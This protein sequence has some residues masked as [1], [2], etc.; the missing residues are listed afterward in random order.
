MEENEYIER[1]FDEH[2]RAAS[3]KSSLGESG[4]YEQI[5]LN[6]KYYRGDQQNGVRLN[7]GNGGALRHNIVRRIGDYKRA[8]IL[9]DNF[10]VRFDAA[11]IA[12][13]DGIRKAALRLKNELC[14]K[15]ITDTVGNDYPIELVENV[16]ALN[17]TSELFKSAAKNCR[18]NM[19]LE[20]ALKNAY[21]SGSGVV[22]TYWDGGVNTG[23]YADEL[24]RTPILGDIKAAVIGIADIDFGDCNE[25]DINRQ[26]YI[27]IA[28]KMSVSAAREEAKL[29]GADNDKLYD[30][31][32]DFD[33]YNSEKC[34]VLTK[35]F[36]TVRLQRVIT[37][38]L[39]MKKQFAQFMR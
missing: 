27:I 1:I 6:E 15:K 3:Y 26:P 17:V 22:Y 28:E 38:C 36:M 39:I 37:I 30:I 12:V 4:L 8:V 32:A 23:F 10:D 7:S 24:N 9:S 35:L 16:L 25:C 31:Q 20:T 33:E 19:L 29:Y 2:E 11:G 13:N 5:R 21:I 18:L 14:G 34:T